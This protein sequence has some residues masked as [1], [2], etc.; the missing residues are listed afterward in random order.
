[1]ARK[2]KDWARAIKRDVHAIYLADVIPAFLGTQ[3]HWHFALPDM[4][5]RL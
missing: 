2:L 4:L 1:M 5:C 3:K